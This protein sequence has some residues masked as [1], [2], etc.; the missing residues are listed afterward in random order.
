[1]VFN[2]LKRNDELK[3]SGFSNNPTN[4]GVRLLNKDGSSNVKKEGI[5]FLSKFSLFHSLINMNW[6][7]FFALLFLGFFLSNVIFASIYIG[8]GVDGINGI[9]ELGI[10]SD[11]LKAFFFSTQ[12]MTTVGYG[13]LSP[14]TAPI[15]T[16]A[17][18]ESFLGLLGFAVA[19][20][21]LYGKFSRARAKLMFSDNA[22]ISPYKEGKGLMVRLANKKASQIIEVKADMFLAYIDEN[23]LG[24]TRKFYSLPLEIAKINM[25]ATSWTLVHPLNAE[26]PIQDITPE[27]LEKTHA[28]II[29]QVQGFDVTYN[30]QINTRRSYKPEEFIWNAKFVRILGQDKKGKATVQLGRLSEYNLTD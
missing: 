1:M 19:T 18:I 16:I 13:Q 21:L 17:A 30:Q 20:G 3:D 10:E 12:T 15:S 7:V 5:G 9:E 27:D 23:E 8:L 22:L 25:L 11:Y 4:E 14:G 29:I 26:S 6:G 28:E 2:R 24:V